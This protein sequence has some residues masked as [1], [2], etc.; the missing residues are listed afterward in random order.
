MRYMFFAFSLLLG[1]VAPTSVQAQMIGDSSP[2][3]GIDVRGRT[4]TLAEPVQDPGTISGRVTD[5]VTGAP[6]SS[7]QI[8]VEESGLMVVTDEDGRYLLQNVPGGRHRL[9]TRRIGYG[10]M[11]AVLTVTSGATVEHDFSL[12]QQIIALD[13]LVVT[14]VPGET[15]VR[16][17]GNALERLELEAVTEAAP[18]VSVQQVLEGRT[19]GV[20]MMG[21]AMVGAAPRMRIRGASTFSLSNNPLVYIDG[22]RADSRETTGYGG[23]NNAGLRSALSSLDP[24]Q[25]ERIE[26]L[27]GPAAATLYGTEASRGVVNVITK[28]GTAG[29]TRLDVMVRQGFNWTQNPA[30]RIGYENYWMNP[31]GEVLSLNV[32]DHWSEQGKDIY[33]TGQVQAYSAT[34]TGGTEDAKYFIAGTYSDET[35]I[36]DYNWSKKLNLRTNIDAQLTNYLATTLSMGYTRGKD[37]LPVDGYR[38]V[39]EGVQFGSPRWLPENRCEESPGFGCDLYD[40]FISGAVPARD[41]SLSNTQ[42]LD[43]VTGG[44]TLNNTAFGWLTNRLTVGIDFTSELNV[45]M[46]EFQTNDTTIASLGSV[47]AMGY[48]DEGRRTNVMSTVDYAS[49]AEF[50]LTEALTT[51]TSVGFQYYTRTNSYLNAGGQQFAGPGLST[52]NAT[53]VLGVPGNND[54][55]DKSL[56]LYV[57]ETLALNDRLFLTGAVRVDNH[58]AFGT[59]IEF[60]TYPKASLSWVITDEPWFGPSFLLSSLRLRGAWGR[61]GEQPAAFSALRSWAAVTGPQSTS[62]VTPNTVGNPDLTAEVGEEI[63][64]GFDADLLNA[65]LGLQFSYYDKRTRDAILERDLAPSTGFTGAQFFNAGKIKNRGAEVQLNATLFDRPGLGLDVSFS[66]SWNWAEIEQL[67]GQPGDTSIVFNS[68]SSME[69][70]VGYAPNS[71]FG[72]D[73]VSGDIDPA[74]GATV[75]AMCSDGNGGITP[76]FDASG[77]VVAPRVYLGRAIAPY[78]ASFTTDVRVGRRFRF[79]ALFTSE[80][81]HKRFDNTLRQRCRLYRVC[82]VNFYPEEADDVSLMAGIQSGNAII[83]P[84]VNDVGFVRLKEVS[85][86]YELPESL[87]GV[88]RA[89]AQIAARNMLTFTNWTSSDPE[90]MFSSGSRAFMEQNNMPLP[91][92]ITT[93]IRL[94]F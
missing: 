76:C 91:Q 14:G 69:H 93:S 61:S 3:F 48:R 89:V 32:V 27:K 51:A 90:T 87:F 30:D 84:W 13:A 80:L 63:E 31:E 9:L 86:S 53:A 36:L 26:V 77:A 23:G 88:R 10:A 75:N 17:V 19:P 21:S 52:V 37:R 70:R 66:G 58:S 44:I 34:L 64:V 78:E 15:R 72:V 54:I 81:G 92:Q 56:G 22:V 24:E 73:V 42:N 74:T 6:I 25:I 47:A 40:G 33:T 39:T 11:S 5:A 41:R 67:S 28:R 68:W 8:I 2:Q 85:V 57:Q 16:A 35:G 7:V 29:A 38:S 18:V 82:R 50:D 49:T 45:R 43:R 59:D 83:D 20:N 62:G 55:T 4:V 71:W 60:V 65:R 94:S 12:S 1:L 79:H 46:R